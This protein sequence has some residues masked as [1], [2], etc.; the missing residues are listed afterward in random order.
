MDPNREVNFAAL[1]NPVAIETFDTYHGYIET[2]LETFG[3]N[4]RG[5]VLDL[6][7]QVRTSSLYLNSIC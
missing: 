1:G 3:A 4:R 7:G 6:H 5:L 2:A